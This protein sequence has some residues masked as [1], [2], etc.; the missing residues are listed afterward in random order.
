MIYIESRKSRNKWK[1]STLNYS[2][3]LEWTILLF[4]FGQGR[5]WLNNHFPSLFIPFLEGPCDVGLCRKDGERIG[6]LCILVHLG[7]KNIPVC[8]SPFQFSITV[9]S[10][11]K[12]LST[13]GIQV[14]PFSEMKNLC[15]NIG[16]GQRTEKNFKFYILFK[17][18]NLIWFWIVALYL[19]Q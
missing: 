10:K 9:C 3:K 11:V 14:G 8:F 6:E 2:R 4:N 12:F 13:N 7:S 18:Q 19:F 5:R 17:I 16:F 1:C 15:L